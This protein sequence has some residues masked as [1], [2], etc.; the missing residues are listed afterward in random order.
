MLELVKDISQGKDLT[1][2]SMAQGG[3]ISAGVVGNL[4]ADMEMELVSL[5]QKR[6]LG[7]S[8]VLLLPSE[9]LDRM[10]RVVKEMDIPVVAS[11]APDGRTA[12]DLAAWIEAVHQTGVK[13]VNVVL[14]P[15]QETMVTEALSRLRRTE[16]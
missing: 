12:A 14:S 16:R 2:R 15:D 6:R 13:G 7:A 3:M 1:G 5:H 4:R 10:E 11:V 8:S 9:A